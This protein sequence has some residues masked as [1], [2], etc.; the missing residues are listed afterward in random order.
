V[1]IRNNFYEFMALGI[2]GLI[3]I[4][5]IKHYINK[6][7]REEERKKFSPVKREGEAEEEKEK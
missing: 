6:M 1:L 3:A 5:F 2:L 7:N 4:P